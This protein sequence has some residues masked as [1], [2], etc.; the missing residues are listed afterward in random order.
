LAPPGAPSPRS[1]EGRK[2]GK[3]V[4]GARKTK[5]TGG[6][7]LA[8]P[9]AWSPLCWSGLA[10]APRWQPCRPL[11]SPPPST[12]AI[13]FMTV[14]PSHKAKPLTAADPAGVDLLVLATVNA[15]YRRSISAATLA[16]CLAKAELGDWEVHIANFFTSVRPKL[17]FEFAAFHR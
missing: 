7:A 6:G 5:N 10:H 14:A 11:E 2:Q 4:P 16:E 15:P 12:A 9:S 3:G 13:V 17:V 1:G 8:V